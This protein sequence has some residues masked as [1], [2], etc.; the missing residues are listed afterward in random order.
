MF[1]YKIRIDGYI[2]GDAKNSIFTMP[3][4][5]GRV[6]VKTNVFD[7]AEERYVKS[8]ESDETVSWSFIIY[9]ENNDCACVDNI[10]WI[11]EEKELGSTVGVTLRLND[12][13]P[14]PAD[15]FTNLTGTVGAAI[16]KRSGW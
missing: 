15:I 9:Y 1:S 10:R 16:S 14:A 13:T 12:G 3:T 8:T 6:N 11:P 2:E 5:S 7:W 4:D